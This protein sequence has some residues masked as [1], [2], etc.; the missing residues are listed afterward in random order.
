M[1][2]PST[3]SNIEALLNRAVLRRNMGE[4]EQAVRDYDEIIRPEPDDPPVRQLQQATLEQ[5]DTGVG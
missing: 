4:P 5:G 3:P 1:P 2:S